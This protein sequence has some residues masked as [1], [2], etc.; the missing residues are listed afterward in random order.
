MKMCLDCV[1]CFVRQAADAVRLSVSSEEEQDRLMHNVLQWIGDIDLR[2]TPPA[3]AQMLHRRLRALLAVEDP[4]RTSK[5]RHNALAA[6]L[7]PSI[8]R[9]IAAAVDP[10]TMAVRYAI[11]GN[12]I[13]LGAKNNVGMGEVY[14]ELQSAPMQ[15]VFGDLEAFKKAAG[16]A[17]TILYLADNAGEIF[18][19][20]LR[21]GHARR[22]RRAG[23]QRRN[24]SR[25]AGGGPGR[26]CRGHG[27]R[28]GCPGHPASRL[29]PRIP[30]PVRR[31]RHDYRQGPGQF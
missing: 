26:H 12:I 28:L 5:N 18:F 22:P 31:S 2:Q 27:Q 20:R 9:R 21:A 4:Y 15:P 23:D 13:D 1:P 16:R 24:A 6:R 30:P 19:D 10:L 14:A 11:T 7:I 29:Q 8:R 25:R 3:A 17:R